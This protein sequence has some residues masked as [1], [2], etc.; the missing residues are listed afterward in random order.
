MAKVFSSNQDEKDPSL[1]NVVEKSQ[2]Y[3]KSGRLRERVHLED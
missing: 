3:Q 2:I 1:V